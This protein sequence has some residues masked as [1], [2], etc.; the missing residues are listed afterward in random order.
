M[1]QNRVQEQA[2][3]DSR[4][5]EA[6]AHSRPRRNRL[7]TMVMTAMMMCLILVM[8]I[9]IRIP[10]PATEGYIHL[11]DCM[12]FLAV[13]L[14][15]W[16]WGAVAAGVGSALADL[17][18]GF[19]AYAPITLVVK[20]VMALVVGLFI[21]HALKHNAGRGR[22][23]LMEIIGMVLGGA[24]MCGGYYLA[25]S[26]M[27]GSWVTPLIS[28]AM[29]TLQFVIGIVIATLLANALYRTPAARH[30]TYRIDEAGRR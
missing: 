29:N 25:E 20:A 27:Y 16:K 7:A 24:V 22:L 14:L 11:G 12:I 17:I 19:V 9:L 26:I 1:S 3:E 15:G 8:T 23:L 4:R 21:S 10:I 6:P 30:F 13:L 28:M 18:G 2:R 5:Q